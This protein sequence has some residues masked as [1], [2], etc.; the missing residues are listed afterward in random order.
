MEEEE[1]G[2]LSGSG[3]PSQSEPFRATRGSGSANARALQWHE[4]RLGLD[5]AWLGVAEMERELRRTT[6][7]AEAL[8]ARAGGPVGA[9][10]RGGQGECDGEESRAKWAS[11][12]AEALGGAAHALA[13]YAVSDA[14]MVRAGWRAGKEGRRPP[15]RQAA[16]ANMRMGR[17]AGGESCCASTMCYLRRH[18]TLQQAWELVILPAACAT[19]TH[20]HAAAAPAPSS[21][22]SRLPP[23]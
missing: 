18:S 1:Q 3:L 20:T 2:A 6:A 21:A 9:A 8:A 15:R 4:A 7:T 14:V 16:F 13:A 10:A 19:I 23:G 11:T 5:K 17:T 22:P 12:A